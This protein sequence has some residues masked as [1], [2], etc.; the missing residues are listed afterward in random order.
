[1]IAVRHVRLQAEVER[2][3]QPTHAVRI[4]VVDLVGIDLVERGTTPAVRGKVMHVVIRRTLRRVAVAEVDRLTAVG[5]R[6]DAAD[7]LAPVGIRSQQV[8]QDPVEAVSPLQRH[9]GLGKPFA[10]EPQVGRS[11][12]VL[13]R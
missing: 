9:Q 5:R 2:I 8:D 11:D 4:V 7:I 6:V 10:G 1:M 13:S 12:A 3:L